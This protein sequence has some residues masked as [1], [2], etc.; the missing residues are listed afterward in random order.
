MATLF[1]RLNTPPAM[2][3]GQALGTATSG[4]AE[5]SVYAVLPLVA[6]LYSF[7][8]FPPETRLQIATVNLPI[9]RILIILLLPLI[10]Q[11]TLKRV[12]IGAADIMILLASAWMAISFMDIYGA[13]V[14]IVR[15]L[16]NIIDAAGAYLV[17][18]ISIRSPRDVRIV[19]ILIA[20]ALLLAGLEMTVESL[21]RR[22]IVRPAFQSVFGTVSAG[23]ED[24]G[25]VAGEMMKDYRL[26]GLLRAYGPFSHPI[27]GGIIL[28]SAIVLYL[29]SGLRFWPKYIG[30]AGA[31]LGFFSLSSAAIL[32]VF[33][34]IG[35]FAGHLILQRVRQISWW[36]VTLFVAAALIFLEVASQGGAVNVLV[37]LTLNPQTGYYRKLIWEY[38]TQSIRDHPL[39]GIGYA[40]YERPVWLLPSESVDAHFLAEGIRYGIF[41]PAL[42]IVAIV[43]TQ[44]MLG[45]LAGRGRGADSNLIVAVNACLFILMFGTFTVTYF[46]EARLWF[47]A[48]V[49]MAVSMAR[50]AHVRTPIVYP[51]MHLPNAGG[52]R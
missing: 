28:T 20:P 45:R 35:I 42:T 12:R 15:A 11:S 52:S 38:G 43:M 10:F 26:G 31:F 29:L 22:L 32:G 14:G 41:V 21:T 18:R 36:V 46:G 24:V 39:F 33:L 1:A 25:N 37:R 4:K 16:G 2:A 9:Y 47:M 51:D 48:I 50:L 19:L 3:S 7:F 23:S 5:G 6:L 40:A 30:L 27:L 34:S 49:G 13:G 17:A 44:I 8:L